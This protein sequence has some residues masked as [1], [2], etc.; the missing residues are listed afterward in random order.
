MTY[1]SLN[2]DICEDVS[3]TYLALVPEHIDPSVLKVYFP[4]WAPDV[5]LF[6]KVIM[7]EIDYEPFHPRWKITCLR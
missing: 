5:A 2:R 7:G 6:A 3:E 1:Y 4:S